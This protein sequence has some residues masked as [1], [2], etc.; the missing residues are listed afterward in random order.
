MTSPPETDREYAYFRVSGSFDPGEI[1][2]LLGMEPSE[3]WRVGDIFERRGH[4]FARRD[5]CWKLDSGLNDT[6]PLDLHL[7]ALIKR[8]TPHRDGLLKVA[9]H[10]LVQFVCV[11]YAYQ[12]FSWELDIDV[13]RKATELG[14][15][16]WFDAYSF[17]DHHDEMVELREQL[18]VRAD[19][20]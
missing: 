12:S 3:D 17:G 19:G 20:E 6:H 10:Y 5:S 2:N 14:I 8:L 16:F 11:S 9:E 7:N 15:G 4:Q 1:T 13:Q 18:G